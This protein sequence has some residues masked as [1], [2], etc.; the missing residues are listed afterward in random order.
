M[1]ASP[2]IGIAEL[3]L[4]DLFAVYAE[5]YVGFYLSFLIPTVFFL[6]CF[7]VLLYCRKRYIRH[8]P[9]GSV[10]LPAVKLLFL[11]LKGRW[12]LNPVATWRHWNDG[13]FWECVK[14]GNAL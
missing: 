8:K 10:L 14:V 11:G 1:R 12:H 5:R 13:T 2:W 7:P 4:A 9:E 6:L 3:G